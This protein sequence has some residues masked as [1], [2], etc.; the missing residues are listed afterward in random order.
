MKVNAQQF[1][2]INW[3]EIAENGTVWAGNVYE[4]NRSGNLGPDT[5]FKNFVKS[6]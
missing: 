1:V 2:S 4:E 6:T 5:F 3:G